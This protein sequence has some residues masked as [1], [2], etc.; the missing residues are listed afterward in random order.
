MNEKVKCCLAFLLAIATINMIRP[1][2][3][4]SSTSHTNLSPVLYNNL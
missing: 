2:S 4:F 1:V 3:V